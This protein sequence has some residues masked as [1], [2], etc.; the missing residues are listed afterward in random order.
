MSRHGKLC[1]SVSVRVS[2]AV[3]GLAVILLGPK[4]FARQGGGAGRLG[5]LQPAQIDRLLAEWEKATRANIDKNPALKA[6]AARYPLVILHSRRYV[7]GNYHKSAYSFIDRTADES[8]HN[9]DVQLLFD[10]GSGDNTFCISM[11]TGQQDLMADLGFADFT[12]NPDP[13]KI[14]L[15]GEGLNS[16]DPRSGKAVEGH[17]YLLRVR[18]TNGNKFY[19]LFQVV[20]VDKGSRYVAFLWRLLPGG[21]IIRRGGN[22]NLGE[23]IS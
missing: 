17:V 7:G 6:L 16:W 4:L 23:N 8:K 5:P 11:H 15:D 10:N 9:N 20:A 21:R 22:N 12:K 2:L 1:K 3:L 14:D 13:K 19:V 18:D